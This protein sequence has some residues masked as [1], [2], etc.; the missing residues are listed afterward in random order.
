[1]GTYCYCIQIFICVVRV[2]VCVVLTTCACSFVRV[3]LLLLE[4]VKNMSP[5]SANLR[6]VPNQTTK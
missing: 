5:W 1:M 4:E 2:C 3:S 6:G